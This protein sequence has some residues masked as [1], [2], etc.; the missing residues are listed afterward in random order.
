[1]NNNSIGP[2]EG[3]LSVSF[4][5]R[6]PHSPPGPYGEVKLKTTGWLVWS[7]KPPPPARS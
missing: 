6:K 2:G 1:M 5:D 4:L 3:G 7:V